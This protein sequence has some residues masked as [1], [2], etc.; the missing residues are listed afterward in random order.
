MEGITAIS[1]D[2]DGT[3]WDFQKVMRHS[4]TQALLELG[5]LDAEAAG[6]LDIDKM[7]EIRNRVALEL[8]GKITNL[9]AVRLEAFRRTLAEIGK[10]DD[11]LA[12]HLNAV[13]LKHRFEDAELF[14]D[15]LPALNRLRADHVVGLL[16]NGNSYPERTGLQGIFRFVV[17]SQDY[18]IEKPDPRIFRIA[19][20]KAGCSSEHLLHVG[21]SLS[22]DVAGA[23]AVGI[24]SVWLNRSGTKDMRGVN[25]D[26]EIRSL[27]ELPTLLQDG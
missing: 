20:E 16:S 4:L 15:V 11:A 8:K 9:E 7:A 2:G 18:G 5:R 13:Y 14:D 3:L 24:K 23:K 21:D 1:F 6:M 19:L 10:P 12:E 17:F 27:G 25:P 26:F 22:N